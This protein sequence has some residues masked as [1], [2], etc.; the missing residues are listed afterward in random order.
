MQRTLAQQVTFVA[1]GMGVVVLLAAA[2]ALYSLYTISDTAH[3][4]SYYIPTQVDLGDRFLTSLANV[5]DEAE[6]FVEEQEI[7]DL[8][9]AQ[10]TVAEAQGRLVELHKLE[11]EY[12][13]LANAS[14]KDAPYIA[15]QQARS[16]VLNQ[17]ATLID[18]MAT[19]DTQ[20]L[21]AAGEQVEQ[22]EDAVENLKTAQETF[23]AKNTAA[24]DVAV[25][26]A[27]Q[28]GFITVGGTFGLM[29]LLMISAVVLVQRRIALPLKTLAVATRALGNN[30]THIGVPVTQGDEIGDLQHAFNDMIATIGQQTHTLKHEILTAQMAQQEAKRLRESLAV[31]LSENEAH[32]DALREMSVPILPIT[33]TTLVMPL[34]GTLDEARLHLMQEQALTILEKSSARC[35]LLDITG[36]PVIDTQVAQGFTRIVQSAQ[37][38]GAQIM[39]T[40]IRPEVAQTLVGIGVDLRRIITHST[41]EAGIAYAME[42]ESPRNRHN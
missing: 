5:L 14:T 23:F 32:R 39:I 13:Q 21:A 4:V 41:L 11:A 15:I 1:S 19:G 34:V 28:Q 37:L 27:I 16:E 8:A 12:G 3:R 38:L 31:Q 30:Q 18:V 26:Q 2:I 20:N 29:V 6:A 22:L 9:E 10:A 36:V 17:E 33:G 7:D 24:A 40:G 25:D 35:L 42:R